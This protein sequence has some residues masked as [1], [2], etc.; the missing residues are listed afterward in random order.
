M[1][2]YILMKIL[3]SAPSRYDRGIGILTL[4]ALDGSYDRMVSPIQQGDRVLDIG[5]GTGALTIRAARKGASLV[6]IDVN[7]GMLDI[8]KKRTEESGLGDR[9]TY[10]EMGVAELGSEPD[11]GYDAIMSGLCFSELSEDE[12]GFVL[13]EARRILRPGGR[14]LVADE[15]KPEGIIMR[16]LHLLVRIPLVVITYLLTQTTTRAVSGLPDKVRE[17]GFVVT[18][19]KH[20]RLGSFMELSAQNPSRQT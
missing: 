11:G 4:G 5:C 16:T 20:S 8:A 14:L 17:A 9:V 10:R 15:M 3:E 6:G 1:S 19:V 7:P 12:L 18:S 2:T 13:N